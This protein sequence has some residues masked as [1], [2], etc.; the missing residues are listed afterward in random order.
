[1]ECE[2]DELFLEW[3]YEDFAVV[4]Q[5]SCAFGQVLPNVQ[6]ICKT[7]TNKMHLF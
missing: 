4:H 6:K 2:G 3:I 5:L 7:Q 1:V